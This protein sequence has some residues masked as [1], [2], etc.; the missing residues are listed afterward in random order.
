MR[1]KT[2]NTVSTSASKHDMGGQYKVLISLVLNC[3]NWLRPRPRKC[4]KNDF[5]RIGKTIDFCAFNYAVHALA[6]H[7]I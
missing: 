6:C 3:P 4:P 2:V 7:F 1:K 5:A